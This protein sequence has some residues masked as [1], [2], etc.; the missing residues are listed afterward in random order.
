VAYGR[1][2]RVVLEKIFGLGVAFYCWS[3]YGMGMSNNTFVPG[4]PRVAHEPRI[5][6]GVTFGQSCTEALTPA[7]RAFVQEAG[8]DWLTMMF[9]R[10]LGMDVLSMEDDTVATAISVERSRRG[11]GPVHD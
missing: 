1:G 4:S 7:Y 9:R 3:W 2:A 6:P 10:F 5:T 11:L 8:D